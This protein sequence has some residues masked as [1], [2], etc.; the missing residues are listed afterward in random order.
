[1]G[2]DEI[3]RSS[4][5]AIIVLEIGGPCTFKVNGKIRAARNKAAI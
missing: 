3:L 1:M 2:K 5:K 4:K